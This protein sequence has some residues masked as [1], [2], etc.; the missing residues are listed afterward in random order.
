[1]NEM[2]TKS[3]VTPLS[4]EELSCEE[5]DAVDGGDC[6]INDVMFWL[7]NRGPLVD[8]WFKHGCK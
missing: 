7:N 5:L 2:N 1:M 8:Y 4:D 3:E 6:T